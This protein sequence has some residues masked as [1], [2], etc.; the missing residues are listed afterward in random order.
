[1]RMVNFAKVSCVVA[2]ALGGCMVDDGAVDEA[3]VTQSAAAGCFNPLVCPG[4][5]DIIA[6]LGPYELDETGGMESSRGFRII[7]RSYPGKTVKKLD[8]SGPNVYV[9]FT[10]NSSVSGPGVV[11]LKLRIRH[12]S[13]VDFDIK[14]AGAITMPYYVNDPSAPIFYGYYLQYAELPYASHEPWQDLCAY[15]DHVDH[16]IAGTWAMLWAGDRYDPKTGKIFASNAAVGP[17]FNISCASEAW[18]KV[19]RARST[20]AIYPSLPVALR[21]AAI[22]MFTANYCG[23]GTHYTKLGQDLTWKDWLGNP[24]AA[25]STTEA[26]WNGSGARCL[27]TPRMVKK[28]DVHCAIPACTDDQV[29]NWYDHGYQLSGVPIVLQAEPL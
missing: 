2:L 8:V 24:K 29:K 25:V 23:D 10:D 22:D 11:G 20:G 26:I 15:K 6:A 1:M 13:G 28:A 9:T 16:G 14:F 5:S 17:W 3:V 7:G 4:N 18:V 27:T 21:Q 19:N 12:K